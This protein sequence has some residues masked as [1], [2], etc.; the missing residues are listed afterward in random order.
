MG[1][2]VHDA[3][4]PIAIAGYS[5]TV[6]SGHPLTVDGSA[7]TAAAGRTIN[8]YAWSVVTTS[9]GATAPVPANPSSATTTLISPTTGSYTLRLTVTDN[10][11]ATDTAD[12]TVQAAASA[13]STSSGGGGEL[14]LELIG[15]ALLA[16]SRRQ[17]EERPIRP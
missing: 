5:G 2:A 16:S 8:G 7:S 10:F 1:A 14:G 3:Q 17:R 13:P 6:G 12:L 15:L 4:R 11:G 9:G